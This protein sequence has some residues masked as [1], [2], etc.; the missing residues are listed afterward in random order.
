MRLASELGFVRG[1]AFAYSQ[2]DGTP[3]AE[4]DG[5]IEEETKLARLDAMSALFQTQ[6][7]AW[8]E[9]QVGSQLRVI[10]DR[11]DDEEGSDAAIGRTEF[12]APEIDGSVR[13]PGCA[14]LV[15]GTVLTVDVVA[16]DEMELIG[17]PHGDLAELIRDA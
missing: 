1:G 11:V 17:V 13:L 10:V 2:E 12:D 9:A 3:A 14:A 16:A 5:Q 7:R 15:P 4:L 6:S 8:A